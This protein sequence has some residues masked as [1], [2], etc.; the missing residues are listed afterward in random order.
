M[1]QP[2]P[3]LFTSLTPPSK[4]SFFKRRWAILLTLGMLLG[5]SSTRAQ[6]NVDGFLSSDDD[7]PFGFNEHE[8]AARIFF[9]NGADIMRGAIDMA[10]MLEKHRESILVKLGRER[11]LQIKLIAKVLSKHDVSENE[12]AS[13]TMKRQSQMRP[14]FLY[15]FMKF[16]FGRERVQAFER[17]LALRDSLSDEEYRALGELVY[18]DRAISG[19]KIETLRVQVPGWKVEPT[20]I[21]GEIFPKVVHE[22]SKLAIGVVDEEQRERI[23]NSE[24]YKQFVARQWV[25]ADKGRGRPWLLLT[26]SHR[27]VETNAHKVRYEYKP[28]PTT[29]WAKRKAWF[30][31]NYVAPTAGTHVL[32]AG[33]IVVQF[34]TTAGTV[35]LFQQ[36]QTL[37]SALT[38]GTTLFTAGFA[39]LIG[40]F[41]SFYSNITRPLDPNDGNSRFKALARRALISSIPFAYGIHIF[42]HVGGVA[43]GID[44]LTLIAPHIPLWLN[45]IGSNF[46]N[47]QLRKLA[48]IRE[49]MGLNRRQIGALKI[50][51]TQLERTAV[52]MILLQPTKTIDLMGKG[53]AE[54]EIGEYDLPLGKVIFYAEALIMPYLVL[55]YAKY[56]DYP[57]VKEFQK[58]WKDL[59]TGKTL[60]KGVARFFRN[61]FE[62]TSKSLHQCSS[63]LQKFLDNDFET[64]KTP[65]KEQELFKATADGEFIEFELIDPPAPR[66]P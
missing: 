66:S 54:L 50:K 12:D 32:T 49:E 3:I 9:A 24:H 56:E 23:V 60:V 58:L 5:V 1:S 22:Q 25:Q 26:I 13:E 33:S 27:D 46:A 34:A 45:I 28:K 15:R 40:T 53:T 65:V 30:R 7:I 37:A 55:Q 19:K 59:W 16:F 38:S 18:A 51:Q 62:I 14:P 21:A 4:F 8:N 11:H 43:A 42:S 63:A 57:K 64:P 39:A 47:D 48:D 20:S 10:V 41:V 44:S 61:I 36:D 52:P 29:W 17:E 35:A 6:D 31:A 2:V